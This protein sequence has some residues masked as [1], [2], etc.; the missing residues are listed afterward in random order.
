MTTSSQVQGQPLISSDDSADTSV[1]INGTIGSHPTLSQSSSFPSSSSKAE[2]ESQASDK[3]STLPPL[4]S[5]PREEE[6]P[7]I[8]L[9]EVEG[10]LAPS[11]SR[12][13]GPI[14]ENGISRER[15]VHFDSTREESASSEPEKQKQDG[16]GANSSTQEVADGTKRKFPETLDG[17]EHVV[18]AS[19]TRQF[20]RYEHEIGRGSFKTVYKGLDTETGV[21]VAWCELLVRRER[22]RGRGSGRERGGKGR[23]RGGKGRGTEREREPHGDRSKFHIFTVISV[24]VSK[25]YTKQISSILWYTCYL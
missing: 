8:D 17:E 22:E 14:V 15:G 12:L 21:A 4:S 10:P 20:V 11:S 5:L 25:Y 9:S 7:H 24:K 1:D 13:D 3:S 18:N 2:T 6:Q 16:G 19:P 23:E